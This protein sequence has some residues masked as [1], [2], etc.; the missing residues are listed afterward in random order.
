M[1][2]EGRKE[3]SERAREREREMWIASSVSLPPTTAL[4][5]ATIQP[6]M[7]FHP[8]H[9]LVDSF[10]FLPLSLSS[11]SPLSLLYGA[12]FFSK[13]PPL[14]T[15]NNWST[16]TPTA[17]RNMRPFPPPILGNN[18]PLRVGLL[19][20][21]S[22]SSTVKWGLNLRE[23]SNLKFKKIDDDFFKKNLLDISQLILLINIHKYS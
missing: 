16:P 4:F 14:L 10:W 8:S 2:K 22:G 21:S 20:N 13:L 11:P 9:P 19:L 5:R 12:N 7:D 23:L 17:H 6:E 18:W 3:G 15:T 1:G